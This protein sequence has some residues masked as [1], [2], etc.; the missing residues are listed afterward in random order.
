M[1]ELPSRARPA[2]RLLLPKPYIAAPRRAA[3]SGPATPLTTPP[4]RPGRAPGEPHPAVMPGSKPAA[5]S[6]A[7]LERLADKVGRIIAR[8]VAV[9]R[10]RRGR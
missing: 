5:L 4:A 6:G 1:P 7:E 3:A 10:E 9:E 8:R 2:A